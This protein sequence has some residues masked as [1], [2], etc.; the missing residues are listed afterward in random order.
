MRRA[1]TKYFESS[2]S[3]IPVEHELAEVTLNLT[4][5]QLSGLLLVID[6]VA[7]VL[8]AEGLSRRS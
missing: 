8:D 1:A 6:I 5:V 7:R 2:A 4:L 3:G